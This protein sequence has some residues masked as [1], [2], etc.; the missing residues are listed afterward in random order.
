MIIPATGRGR[1]RMR[2]PR[3]LFGSV[4]P[5]QAGTASN[6]VGWAGSALRTR[7]K[8]IVLVSTDQRLCTMPYANSRSRLIL[9]NNYG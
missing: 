9:V 3:T 8:G 1:V 7:A 2:A 5:G 6:T 4:P